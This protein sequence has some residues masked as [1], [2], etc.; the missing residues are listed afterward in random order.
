MTSVKRFDRAGL[1]RAARLDNGFLRA[2]ARLSRVGVFTY[3]KA[4]GTT[5]RE[6]RTPEEVFAQDAIDSFALVPLTDDHPSEPVTA[7]NA[8]R[9]SVGSVGEPKQDGKFLSATIMVTDSAVVEKINS[10][11]QELSCGYF[12]DLEPAAPGALW[13]DAETGQSIPYN[14]IQRNIRGNHVAVVAKGRAGAEVRVQLDSADAIQIDVEPK[15][16]TMTTEIKTEEVKADAAPVAETVATPAEV[17][18]AIIEV[19]FKAELEKATARADAA[20]SQ[21][22]KLQAELAQ[23]TSL[24]TLQALVNARVELENKARGVVGKDAKFDGLDAQA[25]KKQV[26]LKIDADM[27]IEGKSADYV[28]AAFDTITRIAPK[29]VNP[30]TQ[31]VAALVAS[32]SKTP[33][34]KLSPQEQYLK[35]FFNGSKKG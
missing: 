1:G 30:V 7:D 27:P 24:E 13:L 6:L 20:E 32:E 33:A 8:K 25:I 28:D 21:V 12:C 2:P 18:P 14:F 9:L 35:D 11:K 16:D 23:A 26:I 4:D 19:D 29:N 31:A 22:A 3:A 15:E 5:I 17:A 34:I 10:G